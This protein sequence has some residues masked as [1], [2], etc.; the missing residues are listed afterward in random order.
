M[1]SFGTRPEP[2]PLPAAAPRRVVLVAGEASGDLHAADLVA[3]MRR[4]VPG[5][6]V[7]GIAGAGA[8]REGMKTILDL[9]EINTLGLTEVAGKARAIVRAWRRL[10]A[11]IRS[12]RP[13]LLVLIDFPEFNLAL[14]RVAKRAG[15]PVFYY[16]SP[17]VWAWR[18]GRVR[19]ILRRV[20]R[21]AAFFPF[22]PEVY[23]GSG[24]VAFVGHPLLDRVKVT[25]NREETRRMH[26]FDAARPLVTLLPGSRRGEIERIL[27]AMAGGAERLAE[28]RP[29]Q[30]ALALAPT[31]DRGWIDAALSGIRVAIRV[32]ENDTYDLVAASD[33][34]LAASG[35]VTLETALLERPMVIMYRVSPFTYWVARRVVDV[36]AIGMPNVIA[37][38]KIVPELIQKEVTPERVAAEAAAIL[39]DPA[40]ARRMVSELASVR[41]SLGE[42]GAAERAARLAIGCF[43]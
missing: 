36:P 39:D 26:G 24:K 21:L 4:L 42:P 32:V 2:A 19:K 16:V 18:R 35:T 40:R 33:L 13:D 8:R 23:G 3:A 29:V 15:V 31:V 28:A 38:R 25:K 43:R 9:S 27:P 7:S 41:A 11:E 14:A 20:D 12:G 17:Q 5:L 22:E 30:L 10:R 37:G 6:E 1:P 34:V